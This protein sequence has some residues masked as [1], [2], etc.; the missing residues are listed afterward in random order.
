MCASTELI[1]LDAQQRG[2]GTDPLS[3]EGGV[4]SLLAQAWAVACAE[5]Y[6]DAH[7][8]STTGVPRTISLDEYLDM[9]PPGRN[10]AAAMHGKWASVRTAIAQE[11]PEPEEMVFDRRERRIISFDG[12]SAA[13][14]E[15]LGAKGAGLSFAEMGRLGMG[16]PSAIRQRYMTAVRRLIRANPWM[17]ELGENR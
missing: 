7:C 5:A 1:L 15:V 2:Q 8:D 16:H 13:H 11:A 14:L 10:D 6:H 17:A 4:S 3:Y 9:A 12:M